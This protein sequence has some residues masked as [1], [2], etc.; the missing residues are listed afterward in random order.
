MQ[1]LTPSFLTLLSSAFC[2]LVFWL[3]YELWLH[4]ESFL[5][6]NRW[7]LL[8]A[9]VFSLLIPHLQWSMKLS[10]QSPSAWQKVSEWQSL[11]PE[12]WHL[13]FPQREA[14]FSLSFGQVV[15]SLYLGGLGFFLL[16]S[17]WQYFQVYRLLKQGIA[18]KSGQDWVWVEN[19]KAQEV[20][21]FFNY[22]LV[23]KKE[24]VPPM[25]LAH[26]LVHVRQGHSLDLLFME[27]LCA[28]FWFHPLVHRMRKRLRE[29]HEYLADQ[30][31]IQGQEQ[32]LY[33]YARLMVTHSS[34]Q[35]DQ[36]MLYHPFAAQ[37]NQRLRR[38]A[39]P[40]SK[41]FQALKYAICLPL[42]T[43]M[44]LFFSVQFLRA[45]PLSEGNLTLKDLSNKFEQ[46]KVLENPSSSS[47]SLSKIVLPQVAIML[48]S[49][50]EKTKVKITVN[51][52]R[53]D[54]GGNAIDL[55]KLGRSAGENPLLILDGVPT[56]YEKLKN[57]DPEIIE[58]INVLKGDNAIKE[59]GD[60]AKNGVLSVK[61][62]VKPTTEKMDKI[63]SLDLNVAVESN[64]SIVPP[65]AETISISV[66]PDR[67]S[68]NSTPK[69][70]STSKPLVIIDGVNRG[71]MNFGQSGSP[72]S[73]LDPINI[74][75]IEIV[76]GKEAL[77]K[78]GKDGE[79]GVVIITT[80][81][82]KE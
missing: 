3:L 1:V 51:E 48:D 76:K 32:G 41:Q 61:T 74:K 20:A 11:P 6:A 31:V 23:P 34:L 2:L 24:N 29:T 22:I 7:Y 27:I 5:Q 10:E 82:K 69:D 30:G 71:R 78:Y 55:I 9:P 65:N 26:E 46:T 43:A 70:P 47:T 58:S 44:G 45:L 14:M 15:W 57:L 18:E 17:A 66:N 12:L 63:K 64:N 54:E 67:V 81:F 33:Q 52:L 77:D 21:S 56:P 36:A 49:V 42:V 80:K 60:L 19:P 25:V 35:K 38:L 68:F 8:L 59:F 4:R 28:L 79:E 16:R 75:K 40:H 50:P 39:Q 37:I 72:I 62:K 13:L 53:I 73:A